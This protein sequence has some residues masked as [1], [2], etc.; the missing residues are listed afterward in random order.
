M[1]LKNK[2][3]KPVTKEKESVFF[4]CNIFIWVLICVYIYDKCKFDY[5]NMN[6]LVYI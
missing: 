4:S 1:V 3:K 5:E 2:L 6:N